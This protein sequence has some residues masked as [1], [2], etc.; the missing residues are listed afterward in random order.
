MTRASLPGGGPG[1]SLGWSCPPRPWCRRSRGLRGV[2]RAALP[3]VPGLSLSGSQ[4][5]PWAGADWH[6]QQQGDKTGLGGALPSLGLASRLGAPPPR[7]EPP[8]P[9]PPGSLTGEPQGPRTPGQDLGTRLALTLSSEGADHGVS[10]FPGAAVGWAAGGAEMPPLCPLLGQPS[11]CACQRKG[12]LLSSETPF[13]RP[14][15]RGLRLRGGVPW[16]PKTLR[17]LIWGGFCP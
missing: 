6:P 4:T 7:P 16:V 1:P 15:A 14:W 5:A 11:S 3:R 10:M 12:G 9:R 13:T 17:H 8:P 2:C